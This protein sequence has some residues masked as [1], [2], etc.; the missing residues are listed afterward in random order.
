MARDM[1]HSLHGHS[2]SQK[3]LCARSGERVPEERKNLLALVLPVAGCCPTENGH[4]H[5]SWQR[6]KGST[7]IFIW[8][9]TAV[10]TLLS[11]QEKK[12]NSH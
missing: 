6:L 1:H 10:C 7:T 11:E 12:Q 3:Q 5:S 9:R 8:G 4:G 2:K